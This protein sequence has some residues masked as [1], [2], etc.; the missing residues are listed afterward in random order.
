MLVKSKVLE[1]HAIS[2]KD[3]IIIYL[4]GEQANGGSSF[5]FTLFNPLKR[6]KVELEL[7]PEIFS[8]L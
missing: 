5:R 1:E 4:F 6:I 2:K 7:K 3:P 8:F